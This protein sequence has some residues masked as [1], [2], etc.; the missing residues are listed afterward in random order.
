MYICEKHKFIIKPT[1]IS[2]ITNESYALEFKFH[3]SS[4]VLFI[5]LF[6]EWRYLV[7]EKMLYISSISRSSSRPN[8]AKFLGPNQPATICHRRRRWR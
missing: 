1:F 6:L 3:G 2:F 8:Q 4:K 5:K 7:N